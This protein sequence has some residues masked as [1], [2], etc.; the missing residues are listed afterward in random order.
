V[1]KSLRKKKKKRRSLEP[2]IIGSGR[3][4][5]GRKSLC[6]GLEGKKINAESGSRGEKIEEQRG[7]GRA[8]DRTGVSKKKIT[9]GVLE[10]SEGGGGEKKNK[11]TKPWVF[12]PPLK[13]G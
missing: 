3:R 9:P 1:K 5:R 7:G 4:G 6:E 2:T 12:S 8:P 13:T 10:K 11:N